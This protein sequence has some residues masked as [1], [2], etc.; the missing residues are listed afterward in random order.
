MS[1]KQVI[2]QLQKRLVSLCIAERI[3]GAAARSGVPSFI[4]QCSTGTAHDESTTQALSQ[5]PVLNCI[6]GLMLQGLDISDESPV[7]ASIAS[8]FSCPC[9]YQC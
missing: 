1:Q 6:K 2:K 7:R 8:S 9:P 3:E 4:V 5:G